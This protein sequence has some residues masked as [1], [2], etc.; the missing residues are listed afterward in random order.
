MSVQTNN[1]GDNFPQN[2][3]DDSG[4]GAFDSDPSWSPLLADGSTKIAFHRDGDIWTVNP[5]DLVKEQITNEPTGTDS[6]PNWSPSGRRIAFQSNRST[7]AFPNPGNDQE[8]YTIKARPETPD[9]GDNEPRRLTD[10]TAQDT[11]PAWS[12]E[13]SHIAFQSTRRDNSEIW[14]M[15]TLSDDNAV[16]LTNNRGVDEFPDWQPRPRRTG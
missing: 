2:L 8:I 4:S 7:A 5:A 6:W 12:P 11:A 10:N 3:T 15:S 14:V 1:T 9:T 16:R 13:G